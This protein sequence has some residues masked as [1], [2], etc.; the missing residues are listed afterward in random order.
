[1][2]QV[3]PYGTWASPITATDVASEDARPGW[4]GWVSGDLWWTESRPNEGGRVT[5]MRRRASPG[6]D[7]A[8]A[9]AAQEMLPPPWYV[10]S[11]VIEYGGHPWAARPAGPR[12]RWCSPTGPASGCTGWGRRCRAASRGR[13]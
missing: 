6:T 13:S 9:E 5:L 3:A 11:R 2:T 12:G 1:M 7:P 10:R 8:G 4:P